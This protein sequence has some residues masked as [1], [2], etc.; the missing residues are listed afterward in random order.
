MNKKEV[1]LYYLK[2]IKGYPITDEEF[3]KYD[4]MWYY[5]NI[6]E[7]DSYYLLYKDA[8]FIRNPQILSREYIGTD[9]DEFRMIEYIRRC[10]LFQYENRNNPYLKEFYSK[11]NNSVFTM[12][13]EPEE[14]TYVGIDH[15]DFTQLYPHLVKLIAIGNTSIKLEG[16]LNKSVEYKPV[17][18][19]NH[20]KRPIVKLLLNSYWGLVSCSDELFKTY[21]LSMERYVISYCIVNRI[22]DPI[23]VKTDGIY[24]YNLNIGLLN[25]FCS[26]LGFYK[27]DIE[28]NMYLYK[29][30]VS[31]YI[32]LDSNLTPISIVGYHFRNTLTGRGYTGLL[33]CECTDD[34]CV[35]KGKFVHAPVNIHI[36]DFNKFYLSLRKEVN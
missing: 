10:N 26:N 12:D 2:H 19:P 15:F 1:A 23:F 5:S 17:D 18:N 4:L 29:V 31:N 14:H 25:E 11:P 21:M 34:W 9:F 16:L 3:D 20:Y 24:G 22:I 13:Y 28:T 33:C 35:R 27:P 7:L 36:R 30:N 32:T 6:P 8:D